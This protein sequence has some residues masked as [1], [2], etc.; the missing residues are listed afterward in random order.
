M[1]K[2][3]LLLAA[4]VSALLVL[5][6]AYAAQLSC[7]NVFQNNPDRWISEVGRESYFAEYLSAFPDASFD[8][9]LDFCIL[10]HVE[11]WRS[12]FDE[13]RRVLKDGGCIYIADL[14]RR[15]IHLVDAVLGWDHAEEALFSFEELEREAKRRG[16]CT[17]K[18]AIDLGLEGYFCFRKE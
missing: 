5:P 1:K 10:H 13:C 12:F 8:A 2:M 16:F 14:S 6:S 11:G 7:H 17:V 4:A 18:K 3:I 9:V 15:C